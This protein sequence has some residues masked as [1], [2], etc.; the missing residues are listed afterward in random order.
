MIFRCFI[1]MIL[2]VSYGISPISAQGNCDFRESLLNNLDKKYGELEFA[3]GI[4]NNGDILEIIVDANDRS[5]SVLITKPNGISC[6]VAVG[7][8]FEIQTIKTVDEES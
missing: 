3:L 4:V 1:L 8:D 5:W 7:D 6:V 2:M